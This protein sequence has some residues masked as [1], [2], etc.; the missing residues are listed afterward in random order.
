MR[1]SLAVTKLAIESGAH[2]APYGNLSPLVL[3]VK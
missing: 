2:G 1:T 3:G